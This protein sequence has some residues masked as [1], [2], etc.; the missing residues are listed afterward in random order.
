VVHSPITQTNK[1]G[2]EAPFLRK[3]VPLRENSDRATTNLT[4][5]GQSQLNDFFFNFSDLLNDLVHGGPLFS[6]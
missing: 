6:L 1:K 5:L 2:A 4:K 3:L